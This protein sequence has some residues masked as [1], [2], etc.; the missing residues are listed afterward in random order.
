MLPSQ[1]RDTIEGCS[2]PA[3]SGV[4]LT[5][6]DVAKSSWVEELIQ[7]VQTEV[8]LLHQ[9][10][11]LAQTEF[12]VLESGDL[13]GLDVVVSRKQTVVE[14]LNSNAKRVDALLTS[15]GV[16]LPD[17]PSSKRETLGL[18]GK[19]GADLLELIRKVDSE[20]KS[21]LEEHRAWIVRQSH[22]IHQDFSLRRAYHSV[23]PTKVQHIN[24]AD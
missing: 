24:L 16:T 17:L 7:G 21:R 5:G 22:Q 4:K 19:K 1:L 9:L 18:L 3:G 11:I 8:S 2:A 23:S 20:N 12:L 6:G 10:H 13:D 15:A 14:D